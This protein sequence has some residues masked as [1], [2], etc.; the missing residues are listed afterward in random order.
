MEK[1]RDSRDLRIPRL[2][3]LVLLQLLS[4]YSKE[5]PFFQEKKFKSWTRRYTLHGKRILGLRQ[6]EQ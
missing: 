2:I 1:C 5:G 3:G 4:M 6:S